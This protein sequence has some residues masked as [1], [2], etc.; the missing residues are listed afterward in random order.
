MGYDDYM[1]RKYSFRGGPYA[2]SGFESEEEADDSDGYEDVYDNLMGMDDQDAAEML[3]DREDFDDYV[4][5]VYGYLQM[6]I[7]PP[8]EEILL[9]SDR[10]IKR[11]ETKGQYIKRLYK[12]WKGEI[13]C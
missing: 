2:A 6:K 3:A 5:L 13:P 8:K 4:A 9:D 1:D 7:Q 12:D 10:E 11:G